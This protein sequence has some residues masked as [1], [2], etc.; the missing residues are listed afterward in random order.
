MNEDL[1]KAPLT[2]RLAYLVIASISIVVFY[3]AYLVVT[4]SYQSD[5]VIDIKQPIEVKGEPVAKDSIVILKIDYC[6]R[7]DT[8]GVVERK[9][10]SDRAEYLFPTTKDATEAECGKIEAPTLLPVLP[11]GAT[12]G[13]YHIEYIVTY[14]IN[15]LKT[16]I[17]E[18]FKTEE[19][20]VE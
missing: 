10:V 20:K 14:D 5:N 13:V 15:P 7:I 19:F 17:V 4:W 8:K 11:V 1:K 2:I 18:E 16:G 6:K 12:P 3:I 9:L